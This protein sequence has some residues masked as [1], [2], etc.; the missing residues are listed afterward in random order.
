V[1][2]IE[3]GFIPVI[4][5]V[6]PFEWIGMGMTLYSEQNLKQRMDSINNLYV[7]AEA[8]E[9]RAS[10]YFPYF[11]VEARIDFSDVRTG[12]RETISL[13][14]AL[15]IYSNQGD[16]LWVEDMI[17][18]VNP[19]KISSHPPESFYLKSLPD[20]LNDAFISRMETQ[21]FQYLLRSFVTR[22]FRNSVLNVYSNSGESRV[23]FTLRC[24]DL[25]DGMMR[26]ELDQ[27]RDIFNRRLEQFREKYAVFDESEAMEMARR[28]SQIRDVFAYYSERIVGLFLKGDLQP[29][30]VHASIGRYQ[31]VL[32]LEERLIGM[33]A[34]AQ[35]AVIELRESYEEKSRALDEYILHPNLKDIHIVRSGILWMP[36]KAE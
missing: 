11:Y 18:D 22:I 1:I 31:G 12:F 25:F 14:K 24:M 3:N 15:E 20:F 36:Q 35:R 21:F 7:S 34:E 28:E 9:S 30:A 4:R 33:E 17:Q 23:D 2:R 10:E 13:N 26:Q 32:E 27:V 6:F 16:L 8:F 29:D 19:Q 5:L